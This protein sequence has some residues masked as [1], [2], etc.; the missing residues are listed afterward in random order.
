MYI[1]KEHPMTVK[2]W[3]FVLIFIVGLTACEGSLDT[4]DLRIG[5]RSQTWI[6]AP[7]PNS[8]IPLQTYKLMFHGASASGIAEFEVLINGEL[9]TKV[10]LSSSNMNETLYF[11]EY[12]WT[13]A[14]PGRFLIE[15]KGIGKKQESSSDQVYV[16]VRGE[17][18]EEETPE[19]AATATPRLTAA[20]AATNTP[21]PEVGQIMV[22]LYV[23]TNSNG[24]EDRSDADYRNVRVSLRPCGCSGRCTESHH[25]TTND[26]GNAYFTNLPYGPYCVS[27][28]SGFTPTTTYPVNVNVNSPGLITINIGYTN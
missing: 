28:T 7:L 16:T 26:D 25:A 3:I 18:E 24:V 12:L 21:V 6:D 5:G 17:V 23:D 11:G 13:P 22:H 1:F 10:L 19:T 2:R 9:I 15:I 27:T 20:P 8:I 14:A 4:A